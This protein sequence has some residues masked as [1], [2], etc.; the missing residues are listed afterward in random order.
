MNAVAKES[1]GAAHYK[2]W[3][4]SMTQREK[5]GLSFFLVFLVF[6]FGIHVLFPSFYGQVVE[7]IWETIKAW[8]WAVFALVVL[9]VIF[10]GM[11]AGR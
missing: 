10:K 8:L 3:R 5:T 6:M 9:I 7:S 4:F 2:K 1:V 11:L